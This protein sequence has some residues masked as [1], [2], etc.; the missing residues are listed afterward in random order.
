MKK[1]IELWSYCV[2]FPMV[3]WIKYYMACCT[4]LTYKTLMSKQWWSGA[5]PLNAQSIFPRLK[6]SA[7]QSKAVFR[8]FSSVKFSFLSWHLFQT[9][10][11]WWNQLMKFKSMKHFYFYDSRFSMLRIRV[12]TFAYICPDL[13][14]TF[15]LFE[16]EIYIFRQTGR[17]EKILP[18][19]GAPPRVVS[20]SPA[21]LLR[22]E[23]ELS[24]R[25]QLAA[26]LSW[27]TQRE[28]DDGWSAATSNIS[29]FVIIVTGVNI[30]WRSEAGCWW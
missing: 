25:Q 7:L 5:H 26:V 11:L 18:Q 28:W 22:P 4:A 15:L 17:S 19:L 2:Y 6:V 10:E 24:T 16:I 14:C 13:Y 3:G 12:Q 30:S 29:C 27:P 9:T 1:V 20:V 21:T 23:P 8:N